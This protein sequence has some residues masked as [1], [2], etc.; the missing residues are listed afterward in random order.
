MYTV[1]YFIKK[2]EA[3]PERLWAVGDI[4]KEGSPRCAL[5]HCRPEVSELQDERCGLINLIHLLYGEN[6]P[7]SLIDINNGYD[8]R[9]PQPTP[10][11]R[12]LAALYDIK[13]LQQPKREKVKA[14]ISPDLLTPP[15]P[16]EVE[17]ID[18]EETLESVMNDFNKSLDSY[19]KTLNKTIDLLMDHAYEGYKRAR[20]GNH[21]LTPEFFEGIYKRED[22]EK[23]ESRYQSELKG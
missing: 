4:G 20:E 11:Q 21:F 12:I 16:K 18:R 15:I 3:I 1:D 2:F 10:K 8:P 23:F 14:Q 7:C 5:G 9:Y 6:I 13:K 19:G 22:I 17:K